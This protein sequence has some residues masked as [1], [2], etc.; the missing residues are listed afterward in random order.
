MLVVEL[1]DADLVAVAGIGPQRLGLLLAVVRDDRVG[2][3]QNRLRRAVV[4]LELDDVGVRERLLE[5]EDIGDVC[6]TEAVDRL[7]VV[8]DHREVAVLAGEQL[9]PAVLGGVRVLV[10]VD[11]HVTEGAGVAVTDLLEQRQDVDRVDE[12]VIEVHR[13]HVVHLALVADERLGDGLLEVRADELLVGLGVTQLVLRVGDLVL[14]GAGRVALR[15][16]TVRVEAALDHPARVGLVVDRELPRVAKPLPIG[17]QH[18]RAGGMERHDP[19][20]ARAPAD[21]QLDALAHLERRLVRERDRQDLVRARLPGALEERDPVRQH[22][23]LAGA[24]AGEDQQRSLAV[25]DGVALGRVE[26]DEQLVDA[27]AGGGVG[28][29]HE[30]RL[31]PGGHLPATTRFGDWRVAPYHRASSLFGEEAGGPCFG[32]A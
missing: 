25:R 7:R 23:G 12:Q 13:V 20:R 8:A 15:V 22:A 19:H 10:L 6:S 1:A 27:V 16:D 17:A 5:R 31:V 24:R 28:H 32:S 30:H 2:R 3:G 21:E 14:H 4:L 18:P 29:P 11:E 26:A 9:Q